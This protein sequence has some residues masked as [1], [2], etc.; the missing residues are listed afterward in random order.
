VLV[1]Q[2]D[3]SG[4]AQH[5]CKG[6]EREGLQGA[7]ELWLT[8]LMGTCAGDGIL[9]SNESRDDTNTLFLPEGT[10]G[11]INVDAVNVSTIDLPA[12][13]I[14]EPIL[15]S[16]A[17]AV[18]DKVYSLVVMND[19][20]R[21]I[22]QG[23]E[24]YIK[25]RAT[26][27]TGEPIEGI[28][29]ES[30]V[31]DVSCS[32]LV[33]RPVTD[34]SSQNTSEFSAPTQTDLC[35][36]SDT[37]LDFKGPGGNVDVLKR[38]T[39]TLNTQWTTR[40]KMLTE[41]G[42]AL[43]GSVGVTDVDG[44]ATVPFLLLRARAGRYQVR[45]RSGATVTHPTDVIEVTSIVNGI[46]IVEPMVGLSERTWVRANPLGPNDF[47]V[48]SQ[49][50]LMLLD[51]V[52]KITGDISSDQ[53]IRKPDV[54]VVDAY[55]N[56]VKRSKEISLH[57]VSCGRRFVPNGTISFPPTADS[58]CEEFMDWDMDATPAWVCRNK[59]KCD[60]GFTRIPPIR[61]WY[62]TLSGFYFV[63]FA[64]DGFVTEQEQLL[65]VQNMILPADSSVLSY[66]LFI[67]I[68]LCGI[69]LVFNANQ[70]NRGR[71]WLQ[72][73][74]AGL[75]FFVL[76]GI[77]YIDATIRSYG[78]PSKVQRELVL[79]GVIMVFLTSSVAIILM[80]LVFQPDSMQYFTARQNKYLNAM[81]NLFLTL[82]ESRPQ[83]R[84]KTAASSNRV[85]PEAVS[86]YKTQNEAEKASPQLSARSEGS[87][88]AL[89]GGKNFGGPGMRG[90]YT[91]ERAMLA[92]K[93]FGFFSA[94]ADG[95]KVE[96]NESGET[97]EDKTT[98]DTG[99]KTDGGEDSDR[100][101][102][103]KG[104][105]GKPAKASGGS[106]KSGEMR[107]RAAAPGNRVTARMKVSSSSK[108]TSGKWGNKWRP[109]LPSFSL[110]SILLLRTKEGRKEL[111]EYWDKVF[112]DFINTVTGAKVQ[113]KG[114][115]VQEGFQYPMRLLAG[116]MLSLVGILIMLIGFESAQRR[117]NFGLERLRAE[118]VRYR[119]SLAKFDTSVDLSQEKAAL[120]TPP[121]SDTYDIV[122]L[123]YTVMES[124]YGGGPEL[125]ENL[126][127]A[128]DIGNSLASLCVIASWLWT[129][130]QLLRVYRQK[131][132]A[133]RADRSL[134]NHWKYPIHEA[135]GYPG[136][137]MWAS[138]ASGLLV[139]LPTAFVVAL[140]LFTPSSRFLVVWILLPIGGLLAIELA[141][142]FI[143]RVFNKL[144]CDGPYIKNR[145]I[146]GTY[147]FI[148]LYAHF[149]TGTALAVSRMVLTYIDF[150]VNFGRLDLPVVEG[151]V[152]HWDSGHS[153]FMA[154]LYLDFFYNAPITSTLAYNLASAMYHRRELKEVA[155]QDMT[156][157]G[158]H[159]KERARVASVQRNR[160]HFLFTIDRN[161][162]TLPKFRVHPPPPPNTWDVD[163]DVLEVE[164]VQAS[165]DEDQIVGSEDEI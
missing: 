94:K 62:T 64:S 48:A 8:A 3:C 136:R 141:S 22:G 138:M 70:V 133:L 41:T 71:I 140:F 122:A 19:Y 26:A 84:A 154:M 128:L 49:G 144:A 68:G 129:N 6:T 91:R 87:Q 121:Y 85:Y 66:R 16:R 27:G 1:K 131:M 4:Y 20:P 102:A 120:P 56:S 53:T 40:I 134:V 132:L 29:I 123:T 90:S 17:F 23:E 50:D 126:L 164:S 80:R 61:F 161:R 105:R 39:V 146:F 57:I 77:L 35:A 115:Q 55:G 72:F 78:S 43:L 108:S 44:I 151:K 110:R 153:S 95:A 155:D 162:E 159:A 124:L 117:T 119:L 69:P 127:Y 45:F 14:P 100:Q 12:D 33:V 98:D 160:W 149:I 73:S 130:I 18:S 93:D 10:A 59:A 163:D 60:E 97:K 58:D 139:W 104:R 88:K 112:T 11:S 47:T 157:K 13:G 147:D 99:G 46:R 79:C 25:V 109:S 63:F 36:G 21:R 42:H 54:Q 156:R 34:A 75:A 7:S 82:S 51:G 83:T 30:E 158:H 31:A 114:G 96:G 92:G 145:V 9:R 38:T 125:F 86:E 150:A 67:L 24:V 37:P 32:R 5:A 148:G 137:Q 111:E 28:A 89:L 74:L 101:P 81:R 65:Y 52:H 116:M 2:W 76:A 113:S 165:E 103:Q 107:R 15:C 143:R 142:W 106:E 118:V 135:A 152:Q